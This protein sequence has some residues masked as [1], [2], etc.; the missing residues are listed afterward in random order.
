[1]EG[2]LQAVYNTCTFCQVSKVVFTTWQ[3]IGNH[4]MPCLHNEAMS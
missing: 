3:S 1:M 2:V 4:A